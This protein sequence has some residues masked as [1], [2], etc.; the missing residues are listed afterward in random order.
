MYQTDQACLRL[1]DPFNL[2]M[3]VDAAYYY[4]ATALGATEWRC[5]AWHEGRHPMDEPARG[6]CVRYIRESNPY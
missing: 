5:L 3:V 6:E 1:A 2:E 4:Y